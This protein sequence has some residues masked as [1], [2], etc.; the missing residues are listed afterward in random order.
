MK[1]LLNLEDTFVGILILAMTI[2]AIVQ[3]I[4]RYILKMPLPWVEELTRYLMVWMTFIA[5]AI[6]VA[7]RSHLKVEL[8]ETFL[9]PNIYRWVDMI[10]NGIIALFSAYFGTLALIF[11]RDQISIGQVS[12]AMQ[13]SMAWPLAAFFIGGILMAI[14]GAYLVYEK[15][16]K[17]ENN[18]EKE[19]ETL[20]E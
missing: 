12:P 17:K 8:L 6:A 20:I 18:F 5:G 4:T 11:L 16:M 1:K 3:V 19:E 7:R 14:H 2:F 10:L 9:P 15:A 13:I